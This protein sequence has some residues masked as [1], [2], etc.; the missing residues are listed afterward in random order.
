MRVFRETKWWRAPTYKSR[1]EGMFLL[2]AVRTVSEKEAGVA[3]HTWRNIY[4]AGASVLL[5]LRFPY[6]MKASP[7]RFRPPSAFKLFH[8]LI[9]P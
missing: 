6:K 4:G 3:E 9:R 7:R 8:L 1:E 2:P 5:P